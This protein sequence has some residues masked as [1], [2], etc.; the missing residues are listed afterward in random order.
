M[1][2]THWG[3]HARPD[4]DPVCFQRSYI[5][6]KTLKRWTSRQWLWGTLFWLWVCE[7]KH[8]ILSLTILSTA[9]IYDFAL[10]WSKAEE[11]G[12]CFNAAVS[13]VSSCN[14]ALNRV[15]VS[16]RMEAVCV[17]HYLVFDRCQWVLLSV[18]C[19]AV[20]V[21]NWN[22]LSPRP[23]AACPSHGDCNAV[24]VFQSERRL[25]LHRNW[26]W[27]KDLMDAATARRCL[28]SWIGYCRRKHAIIRCRASICFSM[29]R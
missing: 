27:I 24:V 2:G 12:I 26:C 17:T 1:K 22:V 5:F 23:S 29:N 14:P 9:L 21:E 11:H 15:T 19:Y 3:A 6:L 4:S 10:N 8:G 16:E 7:R 25:V 20:E 13:K 28:T 18:C